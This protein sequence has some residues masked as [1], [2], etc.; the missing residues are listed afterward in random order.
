MVIAPNSTI[1]EVLPE[2]HYL[3]K[4]GTGYSHLDPWECPESWLRKEPLND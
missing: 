1:L 4:L 2:N 3:V